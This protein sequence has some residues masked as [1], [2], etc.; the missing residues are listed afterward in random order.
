MTINRALIEREVVFEAI[1]GRGPGGQ[2]VNKV[3][4]AAQM[5]WDYQTSQEL[6]PIQKDLVSSKLARVIN[7][8]GILYLRSDEFRDLEKNKS[9]CLEKLWALLQEAFHRP[10]VR[11]KTKPSKTTKMKGL[12]QKKKH[13][14]NKKMRQ[15]VSW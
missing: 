7:K 15:K 5:T 1:R 6:S 2:N 11:R 4:S 13:G 8:A 14:S 10:K 12:D 3:S 9:R